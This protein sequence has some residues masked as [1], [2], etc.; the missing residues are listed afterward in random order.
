MPQVPEQAKNLP[1]HV[2]NRV[3][4]LTQE[5]HT[6][7]TGVGISISHSSTHALT[8]KRLGME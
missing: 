5:Q 7:L 2:S 4:G 6:K 3:D 8:R 1:L